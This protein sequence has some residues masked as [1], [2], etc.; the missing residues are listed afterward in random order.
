MT[1]EVRVSVTP[2]LAIFDFMWLITAALVIRSNL[3]SSI[4]V[5]N[6]PQRLCI[7]LS[8]IPLDR[9]R[10]SAKDVMALV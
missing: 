9:P 7:E 2:C 6:N 3:D 4:I 8:L 10:S 1:I 5:H